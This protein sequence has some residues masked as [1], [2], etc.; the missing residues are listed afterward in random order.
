MDTPSQREQY[1]STRCSTRLESF[2]LAFITAI[3]LL[4]SRCVDCFVSFINKDVRLS[5]ILRYLCVCL[6][7]SS[8]T[9]RKVALSWTRRYG[10]EKSLHLWYLHWPWSETDLQKTGLF[11]SHIYVMQLLYPIHMPVDSLYDVKWPKLS[12]TATPSI[13]TVSREPVFL[14]LPLKYC[15]T[16]YVS[17]TCRLIGLLEKLSNDLRMWQ[18]GYGRI[19][20]TK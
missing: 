14:D 4:S 9:N 16:G 5:K 17:A 11:R 13:K 20:F 12:W 2:Y 3:D 8:H 7:H 19:R 18:N 1:D 10:K 15:D 6:S